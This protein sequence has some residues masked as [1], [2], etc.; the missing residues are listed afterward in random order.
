MNDLPRAVNVCTTDLHLRLIE[1][2]EIIREVAVNMLRYRNLGRNLNFFNK[3]FLS[4]Q[5]HN[6]RSYDTL[7]SYMKYIFTNDTSRVVSK[8]VFHLRFANH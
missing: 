1:L 5:Q 2:Q 3:V 4:Y 7:Y 6:V 8:Y